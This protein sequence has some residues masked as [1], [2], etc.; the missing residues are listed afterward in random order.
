M[1]RQKNEG[2]I[3]VKGTWL[4]DWGKMVNKQIKNDPSKKAEYDKYLTPILPSFFC[5]VIIYLL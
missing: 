3:G 5:L 1:T 2:K 4:V